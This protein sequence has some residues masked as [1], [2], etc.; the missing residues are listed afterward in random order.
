MEIRSYRTVFDLER[1]IYRVDRLRLNPGGVPLRGIV[2]FLALLAPTLLAGSLPLLGTAVKALPWYIRDLGLPGAS[3]AV[4]TVIRIE[5]RPFH[6]A[7]RSL[8]RFASGPRQLGGVRPCRASDCSRA[9]QRWYPPPIVSFPDGSDARLRRLR[10]T[11]PGAVLVTVAHQRAEWRV[12]GIG[13]LIAR[14][15]VTLS[16]LP[17]RGAPARGQ[18]IALRRGTRLRVR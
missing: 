12:G 14:P 6:L 13:R 11:G 5:G 4:L 17:G 3:A 9:G 18:V 16:S 10:Y 15:Q 1:R 2:Y 8:L 7:A